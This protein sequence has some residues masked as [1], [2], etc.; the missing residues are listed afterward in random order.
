MRLLSIRSNTWLFVARVM[1]MY[2]RAI[3]RSTKIICR[4]FLKEL[5][6]R[7]RNPSGFIAAAHLVGLPGQS[8]FQRRMCIWQIAQID[9]QEIKLRDLQIFNFLVFH[10]F[11]QS[12]FALN[13]TK[14]R[15]SILQ[16]SINYTHG[17]LTNDAIIE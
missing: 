10:N 9:F 13:T 15:H 12:I 14:S 7:R 11:C 4:A 3:D 5:L 17:P 8:A 16:I 2:R 1:G 6:A